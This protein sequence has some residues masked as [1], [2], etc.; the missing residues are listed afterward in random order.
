[1]VATHFQDICYELINSSYTTNT[2]GLT[3]SGL[4]YRRS[5]MG[6]LEPKLRHYTNGGY[7]ASFAFLKN[8]LETPF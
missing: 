2:D 5:V 1:M 6:Y 8:V 3:L 7:L 4:I